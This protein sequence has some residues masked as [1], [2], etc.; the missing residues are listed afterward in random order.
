MKKNITYLAVVILLAILIGVFIRQSYPR[1]DFVAPAT[2]AVVSVATKTEP[3]MSEPTASQTTAYPGYNFPLSADQIDWEDREIFKSGLVPGSQSVLNQLPLASTYY[4]S[5]EIPEDLISEIKGHL[6]VRYS[7]AEDVNL[8]M[9][10]FRLFPNFQ[11][12]ILTISNLTLDG[13]VS[14]TT[15]ES[16]DPRV[17][18]NPQPTTLRVDLVNELQ[19]G[20]S[21][22]IELD[23][24]LE[25]PTEMGGHYGLYGYFE[26]V[27]VLD[28][29]Y[30]M[31]P[32]YDEKDGWYSG[33]PQPN[34][35]H[36]YNDTSFYIVQVKAPADLVMASSGVVVDSQENGG[37]QEVVYA[38]G[39]ARDFYLAGSREFVEL[40]ETTGDLTIRVLAREEYKLHQGLALKYVKDSIE[41]LSDRIGDYPY[42]EFEVTSAPMR[43]LG[44]EYPGITSITVDEFVEGG[45]M[46][47]S[48]TEVYLESTTVHEVGHA[49]FYNTVG[50]DQ[51]NEPWL[52]EA[53]AQYFTYIYYLDNY[54]NADG[55]VNSWYGRWNRVDNADI[56]IGMPAGAYYDFETEINS[57]GA[58]VYGRGPI[59]FLE[60]EKSLGLDTVLTAIQNYYQDNL[61][62]V[63]QP[64]E[65][66]A[67]L[68]DACQCD[69][70]D[71]WNEW[72]YGE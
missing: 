24:S 29:F 28:T 31:I 63:G 66:L 49:W 64:D 2:E 26:D 21:V 15:L 18:D 41:I 19:P 34:G 3:A 4:I 32:A 65:M 60:L 46:Y 72:V 43:A 6:I 56:P 35:D 11:G 13:E 70:D 17:E 58:I 23:F 39:P 55:Y 16:F 51:Q 30:P 38:A 36:T 20:E 42:T 8:D 44:I 1:S 47:G 67:A 33:F 9:V 25:V 22:N 7:N 62:G 68:E 54:G 45:E 50:N 5:I 61:W 27:L 52:D 53:L 69:L 59:F 71:F 40:E 12:G 14:S 48:P 57:Y 10:Y 37:T